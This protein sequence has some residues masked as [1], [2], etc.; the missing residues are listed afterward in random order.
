[1]SDNKTQTSPLPAVGALIPHSS[2]NTSKAVTIQ[3]ASVPK[4]PIP[5]LKIQPKVLEEEN[6]VEAMD[7]I[8]KRDYFPHVFSTEELNAKEVE[9][10]NVNTNMSLDKFV[11]QHTS[12]DNAS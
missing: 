2:F 8:I 7:K 11:S 9:E 10:S 4:V 1:M 12:E 6:Y 5:K 3:P